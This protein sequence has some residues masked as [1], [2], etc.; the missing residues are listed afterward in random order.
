MIRLAPLILAGL[1]VA[2]CGSLPAVPNPPPPP[3]SSSGCS[4][5]Y[6]TGPTGSCDR[7]E[8]NF[9]GR[10]GYFGVQA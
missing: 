3:P 5:G 7:D 4:P 2:G 9:G 6:H 1:A 10:P 8:S